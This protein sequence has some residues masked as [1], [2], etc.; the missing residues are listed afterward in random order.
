M[1]DSAQQP[2]AGPKQVLQPEE[3][4]QA[5][6]S[7]RDFSTAQQLAAVAAAVIAALTLALGVYTQLIRSPGN[8]QQTSPAGETSKATTSAAASAT[9]ADARVAP[10]APPA[11]SCLQG[12]I[13]VPC[14]TSHE[15]EVVSTATECTLPAV[16]D[17]LGGSSVDVLR[18]DLVLSTKPTQGC[19]VGLAT[20]T[21]NSAIKGMLTT[22]AGAT[23]RWCRADNGATIQCTG[24]HAA[25]VVFQRRPGSTEELNCPARV[26]HYAE[27]A[28]RELSESIR[29]AAERLNNLDSC[30]VYPLGDNQFT[31]TLR[32][33]RRSQ[34][35]VAGK[36]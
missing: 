29:V 20:G 19:T 16:L 12:A 18:P 24:P 36:T 35:P 22:S 9:S 13:K 11:G 7:R 10:G 30:V 17:Y 8:T 31:N 32:S 23:L 1:N 3:P 33:L 14:D 21:L 4:A 26:A 15:R 34:I 6:R 28:W 25:E 2:K 5:Q 27:K